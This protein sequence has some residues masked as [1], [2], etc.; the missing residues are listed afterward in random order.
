MEKKLYT[1]YLNNREEK[2][3]DNYLLD[4]YQLIL[5]EDLKD[6]VKDFRIEEQESNTLGTYSNDK[7]IMTINKKAIQNHQAIK[8]IPPSL[9]AIEVIKHELE[10]ARNLKTLDEGRSNIE[11][12]IINYSLKDYV[13]WKERTNFN[14]P[15]DMDIF[16][17]MMRIKDNYQSNPGERLAEIRGWKYLVNML[18]NQRTSN[19]LLLARTMLY[20][21]Y[22]RGYNHT[23]Y[24]LECPT[25]SF[26]LHTKMLE[27]FY[28]LKKRIDI[29]D[30][31]FD[32]RLTYGLPITE[33]EYNKKILQK[34]KLQKR[35]N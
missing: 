15:M 2:L 20:Y 4:I 21:S 13:I 7:K 24:Y 28:L 5:E 34:V 33:E 18:K 14:Q 8:G 17:L 16:L 25:M 3:K 10:H 11:S 29:E 32:T 31:S 22:I 30:Y 9:Q 6:Y 35:R 26:L 27:D 19:D 12:T 1:T 23:K